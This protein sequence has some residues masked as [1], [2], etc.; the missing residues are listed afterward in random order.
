MKVLQT[1]RERF[2]KD[3]PFNGLKI[4]CCLHITAETACLVIALKE[5]GAEV[6]LTAS[7]PLSTKDD[8]AASLVKDFGI[9][10]FGIRGEDSDS[11]YKNIEKVIQKRLI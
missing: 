1:I 10:V 6:F 2:K 11:Y 7:N 3:K 5:G 8:I 4:G 9:N